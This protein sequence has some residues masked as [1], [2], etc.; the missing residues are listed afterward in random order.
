MSRI[1]K[2]VDG[3]WIISGDFNAISKLSERKGSPNF[4]KQGEI[5]EFRDFL[6]S[7]RLVD[8]PC[9]GNKFT[10]FSGDGRSMSIMDKFLLTE[11]LVDR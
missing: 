5:G 1:N 2:Y 10:L 11:T 3:E 4:N 9:L 6:G 7:S 8:V